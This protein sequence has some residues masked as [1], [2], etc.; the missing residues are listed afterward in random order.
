VVVTIRDELLHGTDPWLQRRRRIAQVAAL[1]A[2]EFGVI[3]MRQYGAI[4]RLPDL[5]VRGFDS[6]AVITSRAA[7]PLG[8]PDAALAVTGAGAIIALATAR[9]A[10]RSPWL[11]L[12]MGAAIVVGAAGAVVYLGAMARQ[13]RACAYCLAGASGFLSLI[14]LAAHGV[15]EAWRRVTR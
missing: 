12:A 9:G 8:I 14:P 10:V 2:A 6:N 4:R 13:R 1:L 7:Y 11:D 15:L 5:P 3:G